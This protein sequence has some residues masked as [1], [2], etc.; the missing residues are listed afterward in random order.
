MPGSGKVWS[1][2]I[3][4]PSSPVFTGITCRDHLDNE[5]LSLSNSKRTL[6]S[7]IG[8]LKRPI[9][10]AKASY[11]YERDRYSAYPNTEHLD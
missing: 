11:L 8:S 4:R 1:N 2:Y 5:T 3:T 6:G 7:R 10:P 9:S